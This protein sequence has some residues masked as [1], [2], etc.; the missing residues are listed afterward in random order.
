MLPTFVP[1]IMVINILGAETNAYFFI[2]WQISMLLLAVPRWTAM[3]LLA[4]NREGFYY[5]R[6]YTIIGVKKNAG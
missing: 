3:S 1:P 4:Y 6:L 5:M 2:A